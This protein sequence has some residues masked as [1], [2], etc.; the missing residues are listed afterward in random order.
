VKTFRLWPVLVFFIVANMG[1]LLQVW[2]VI[3]YRAAQT[4]FYGGVIGM[5]AIV[6]A[7][8]QDAARCVQTEV[9][10]G[11]DHVIQGSVDVVLELEEGGQPEQAETGP[12]WDWR[13]EDQ[14]WRGGGEVPGG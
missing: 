2:D 12:D 8:C 1:F 10:P 4:V 3:S 6:L 14:P 5:F 9:R 11:E 13:E 7:M